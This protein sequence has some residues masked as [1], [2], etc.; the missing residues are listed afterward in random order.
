MKMNEKELVSPRPGWVVLV[1]KLLNVLSPGFFLCSGWVKWPFFLPS[2]C[3]IWRQIQYVQL[4]N[5][6]IES[7]IARTPMPHGSRLCMEFRMQERNVWN[8]ALD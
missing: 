3:V 1:Q 6:T 2:Q 5:Q 8:S 7:V 4:L